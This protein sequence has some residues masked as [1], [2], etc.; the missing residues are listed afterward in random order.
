MSRIIA[1]INVVLL[2]TSVFGQDSILDAI[3]GF[4]KDTE[5]IYNGEPPDAI[6]IHTEYDFIIIGAGT[7][8]C[9]LS[10]RLTEIEKFKVLLIE[11]GGSEQVFMDIPAL[12][13]M[14]QFTDAN[15]D[16][17]TEP[18]TALDKEEE[19]H[20]GKER[21]WVQEAWQ[22]REKIRIHDVIQRINLRGKKYFNQFLADHFFVCSGV[23]DPTKNIIVADY[24]HD[25]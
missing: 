7:A 13:T 17:H 3:N 21:K 20:Q 4:L 24:V 22:L 2:L 15:W 25:Y 23:R 6:N 18:Q 9:V 1:I 5:E 10:N 19:Q 8:G 16:Y 14:L 12:A 11:A